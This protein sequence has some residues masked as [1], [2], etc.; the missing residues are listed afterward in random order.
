MASL[1]ANGREDWPGTWLWRPFNA[2]FCCCRMP[3][4]CDLGPIG[5][6]KGWAEEAQGAPRSAL[7][8]GCSCSWRPWRSARWTGG[9]RRLPARKPV[10]SVPTR[11]IG[12]SFVAVVCGAGRRGGEQDH[13]REARRAGEEGREG[14]VEGALNSASVVAARRTWYRRRQN[15]AVRSSVPLR[16]SDRHFVDLE[17]PMSIG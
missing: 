14:E 6:R 17:L 9:S 5:P 4:T 7:S 1:W 13:H 10:P 3:P 12:V 2:L 8:R 16:F 15:E 11:Q